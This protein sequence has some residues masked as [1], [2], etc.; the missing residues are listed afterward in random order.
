MMMIHTPPARGSASMD[1]HE[2]VVVAANSGG[3]TRQISR[4]SMREPGISGELVSASIRTRSH[5]LQREPGRTGRRRDRKNAPACEWRLIR[6]SAVDRYYD[7]ATGQFLTVDPLVDQ[8]DA[9]YEHCDQDPINCCGLDGTVA[10]PADWAWE[11]SVPDWFLVIPFVA[12][13]EIGSH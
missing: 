7:P 3:R 5:R 12:G 10:M 6:G 11:V 2:E 9:P 13:F 1:G 8:T 4:P